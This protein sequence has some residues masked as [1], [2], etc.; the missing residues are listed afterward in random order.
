MKATPPDQ[1][2]LKANMEILGPCCRLG[3]QEG[4][5]Q[6]EESMFWQGVWFFS[7]SGSMSLRLW[8]LRWFAKSLGTTG[9]KNNMKKKRRSGNRNGPF[10]Q[11]HFVSSSF[12]VAKS[13]GS[14]LWTWDSNLLRLSI[15]TSGTPTCAV[16]GLE[17]DNSLIVDS[18]SLALKGFFY[19]G[20]NDRIQD[21]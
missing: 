7:F 18:R 20:T 21:V 16:Q 13:C 3:G 17:T 8:V 11:A 1:T 12:R 5:N 19:L 4:G 6:E 15:Y 9:L 14:I 10:C 2:S